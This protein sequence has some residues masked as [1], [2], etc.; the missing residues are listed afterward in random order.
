MT[1]IKMKV[2]HVCKNSVCF[3]AVDAVGDATC[4]SIYIMN[5]GYKALN[6]PKEIVLSIE[7]E[8]EVK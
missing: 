5:E 8:K 3:K 4:R 2:D 7:N 6:M 1:K